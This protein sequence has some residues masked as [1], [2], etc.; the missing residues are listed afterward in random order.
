MFIELTEFYVF[1]VFDLNFCFVFITLFF[2][3]SQTFPKGNK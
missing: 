2:L 3:L 1:I